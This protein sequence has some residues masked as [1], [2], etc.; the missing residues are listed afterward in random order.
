MK[1][2]EVKMKDNLDKLYH[3][4]ETLDEK[5]EIVEQERT[6][7]IVRTDN[8]TL[9]LKKYRD[10]LLNMKDS[11]YQFI[12]STHFELKEAIANFNI[13]IEQ[14]AQEVQFEKLKLSAQ[15]SEFRKFGY[16]IELA[17][18]RMGEIEVFFD[19]IK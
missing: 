3:M 6:S 10:E 2:N 9:E 16:E 7:F 12:Q 8:L 13:Q 14:V 5:V 17:N 19:D 15:N 4:N 1:V 11:I 18:R